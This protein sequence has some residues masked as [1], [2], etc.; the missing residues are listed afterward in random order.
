MKRL[1]FLLFTLFVMVSVAWSQ[2][3]MNQEGAEVIVTTEMQERQD[4]QI[5]TSPDE[6]R[7][8]K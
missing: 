7:I 4:V 2:E 8:S 6:R 3:Q 5:A 1:M